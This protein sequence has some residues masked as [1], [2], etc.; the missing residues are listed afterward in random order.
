MCGS[1]Q[2]SED[3]LEILLER[4]GF[5]EDKKNESGT[6][7]RGEILAVIKSNNGTGNEL[8]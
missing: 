2:M 1:P 3:M 7:P 6:D 8:Y 5:R 4:A